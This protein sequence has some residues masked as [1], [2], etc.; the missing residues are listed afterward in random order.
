V[1]YILAALFPERVLAVAALALAY[2]PRGQFSVP[3]FEMSRRF[4]YQWF[5]CTAANGEFVALSFVHEPVSFG[6]RL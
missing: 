5:M 3:S 2:Q 1:A 6:G 4:W